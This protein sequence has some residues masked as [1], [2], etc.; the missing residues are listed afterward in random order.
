MDHCLRMIAKPTEKLDRYA[1]VWEAHIL[2]LRD[3]YA[4]NP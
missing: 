4:M 3:A 2:P 1:R